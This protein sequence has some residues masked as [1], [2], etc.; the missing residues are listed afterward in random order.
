MPKSRFRIKHVRRDRPHCFTGPVNSTGI[1][2]E[3]RN[4][5]LLFTLARK[6]FPLLAV[7]LALGMP[8]DQELD[9]YQEGS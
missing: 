9:V 1:A 2:L 5:S 4:K 3:I 6:Q 7:S 8:F